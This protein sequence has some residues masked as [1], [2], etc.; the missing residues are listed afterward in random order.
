MLNT[1]LHTKLDSLCL[2]V[3]PFKQIGLHRSTLPEYVDDNAKW[4]AFFLSK[5]TQVAIT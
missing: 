1:F 3:Y 5:L 2:L 4:T